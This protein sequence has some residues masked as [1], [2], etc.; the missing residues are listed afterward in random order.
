[1]KKA[2][3]SSLDIDISKP[4]LLKDIPIDDK[5]CFSF[6]WN[7]KDS[8]CAMCASQ[9]ICAIVF[10]QNQSKKVKDLEAKNGSYLDQVYKNSLSLEQFK[11]LEELI[12]N[13]INNGIV[14]KITDV[15]K[16][17]KDIIKTRDNEIVKTIMTEFF[18]TTKLFIYNQE[19]KKVTRK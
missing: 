14:V 1:M 18:S 6:E 2:K 7:P 4:V 3:G 8:I 15:F 10:T 13:N 12:S 5:D 9:T 16:F 19:L 11:S 17:I